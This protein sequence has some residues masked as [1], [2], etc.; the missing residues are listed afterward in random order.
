MNHL[1]RPGNRYGAPAPSV[2]VL[3]LRPAPLLHARAVLVARWRALVQAVGKAPQQL[4]VAVDDVQR[5]VV[6]IA[7][8]PIRQGRGAAPARGWDGLES[9]DECLARLVYVGERAVQ[10]RVDEP[11]D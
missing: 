5:E 9:G 10:V 1:A 4:G 7:R 6:Q 3:P 2:P 8:R 11:P